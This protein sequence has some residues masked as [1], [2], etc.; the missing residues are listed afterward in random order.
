[1][2][3]LLLDGFQNDGHNE[4][5]TGFLDVGLSAF[6]AV[7][8]FRSIAKSDFEAGQRVGIGGE[9][10]EIGLIAE[11]IR[12]VVDEAPDFGSVVNFRIG[13]LK[14]GAF[15]DDRVDAERQVGQGG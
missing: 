7:K 6:P 5:E 14:V 3:V 15:V 2:S 9:E 4:A 8:R 1:M 13:E 12:Q 10:I 11:A